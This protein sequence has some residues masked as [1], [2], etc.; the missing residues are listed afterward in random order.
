MISIGGHKMRQTLSTESNLAFKR[1]LEAMRKRGAWRAEQEAAD[2][3]PEETE[4]A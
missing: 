1:A 2:R 3:E 4:A